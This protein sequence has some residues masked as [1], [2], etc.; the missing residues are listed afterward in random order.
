MKD[1]DVTELVDF[2]LNDDDVLPLLRCVCGANFDPWHF[3]ISVGGDGSGNYVHSCP[4]C[5]R[6]LYFTVSIKVFEVIE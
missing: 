4:V 3:I 2:G 6:K 5:G 1:R